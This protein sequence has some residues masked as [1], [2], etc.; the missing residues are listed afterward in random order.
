[1]NARL[2]LL[3]LGLVAVL[4]TACSEDQSLPRGGGGGDERDT[5]SVDTGGRDTGATDET[6]TTDDTGT[7]GDDTGGGGLDVEVDTGTVDTGTGGTDTGTTDTAPD[8]T[9]G[10]A[11]QGAPCS[12]AADENDE[13]ACVA[14][15]A[16]S[17]PTCVQRC[18]A[19]NAD[20]TSSSDCPVNSWC[21]DIESGIDGLAGGCFTGD[22]LTNFFDPA[23]CGGTGICQPIGNG[24]SFCLDPGTAGEG[25]PCGVDTSA[26]PPPSD[27]CGRGLVCVDRVCTTPCN[28]LNGNAD[29][30][31]G[32]TC[33]AA[34]DF[35]P[36]N[37]P[38]ICGNDC[39]AFSTGECD[40][41]Q[42][43]IPSI[44][45]SGVNVWRC[46]GT[47][48]GNEFAANEIC[49]QAEGFCQEGLLCVNTGEELSGQP[50]AR[51]LEMCDVTE[52]LA[53]RGPCGTGSACA[54]A[55]VAGLGF[56]NQACD[57]F[58]R[59][60]G[61]SYGCD[62]TDFACFPVVADDAQALAPYGICSPTTGTLANGAAC[63]QSGTIEECDDLA[64][65]LDFTDDSRENP[66][67]AALCEPLTHD[68]AACPRG[69]TCSPILPLV[70][71]LA[72]GLCSGVFNPGS[73]GDTCTTEGI[74]CAGP[75]TLCLD[76]GSG[77]T[78]VYACREGFPEDCAG[79][80]TTCQS[81][82][83]NPDVVPS[84]MGLCF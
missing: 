6:S 39:T 43:C 34:L 4:A 9:S 7:G 82:T 76:L 77:P 58:P 35:T 15:R 53:G 24:A 50:V 1:M 68:T 47:P 45:R 14:F 73:E 81:G 54:R 22:C 80:G 2:P 70:G 25:D 18:D 71:N 3:G 52:E 27:S 17:D 5:G 78:C 79:T 42:S 60:P 8:T 29:C 36:R 72:F 19:D 33:L 51:C 26:T 74:P 16:D 44:G 38:G 12:G 69:T 66:T 11:E 32:E 56:C 55:A 63:T 10:C 40:A 46:S 41:G 84:F 67:C 64:V 37:R 62:G 61:G 31:G 65:C 30:S 57:P 83:L 75:G 48:G 23:A 13:F 21:F 49:N 59:T 20:D 28:R